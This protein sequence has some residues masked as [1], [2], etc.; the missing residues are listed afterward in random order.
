LFVPSRYIQRYTNP[1][2]AAAAGDID[3]LW[4]GFRIGKVPAS[5]LW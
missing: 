5:T 4:P 3:E 2:E 1:T